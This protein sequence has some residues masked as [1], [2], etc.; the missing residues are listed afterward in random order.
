MPP[1]PR[2]TS[3]NPMTLT[4]W[5]ALL[6][7]PMITWSGQVYPWDYFTEHTEEVLR[8]LQTVPE[9]QWW[10]TQDFPIVVEDPEAEDDI[11]M[12]YYHWFINEGRD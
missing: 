12:Q 2:H 8:C 5:T 3:L 7:S 9:E 10:G 6:F 11:F 4:S 1:Y